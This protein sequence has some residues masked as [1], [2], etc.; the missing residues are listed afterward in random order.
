MTS[1]FWS[2][3]T[4]SHAAESGCINNRGVRM[5]Q[6]QNGQD[7]ERDRDEE[8]VKIVVTEGTG[9][10]WARVGFRPLPPLTA[11]DL[12]AYREGR[13]SHVV[14]MVD[15]PGEP[16]V[17]TDP[18]RSTPPAPSQQGPPEPPAK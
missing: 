11:E 1:S 8:P 6:S 4:Q 17:W 15:G 10:P 12:A 2:I 13:V 14:V 5:S 7:P 18:P 3:R 9:G 16:K